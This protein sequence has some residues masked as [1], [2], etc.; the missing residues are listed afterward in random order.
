MDPTLVNLGDIGAL[1]GSAAYFTH[2]AINGLTL[3][4]PKRPSWV[5]F[6]GAIECGVLFTALLA[7]A[8]GPAPEQ[9]SIAQLVAQVILVGIAAGG[10]AAG[11]SVT[12]AS[13]EAKRQRATRQTPKTEPDPMTP[14]AQSRPDRAAHSST[15]V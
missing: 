3:A 11:T 9:A 10:A 12:Q 14:K 5:A 8:R 15:A 2:L 7:I 6:V 1:F 4:F 13:A